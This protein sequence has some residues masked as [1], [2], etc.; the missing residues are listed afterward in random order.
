VSAT[1]SRNLI[2]GGR[3]TTGVLASGRAPPT[4]D[5][6]EGGRINGDIASTLEPR[7]PDRPSQIAGL[8]PQ[9]SRLDPR[10]SKPQASIPNASVGAS[11]SAGVSATVGAPVPVGAKPRDRRNAAVLRGVSVATG[12]LPGNRASVAW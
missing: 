9:V 5:F 3:L 10:T 12:S 11:A 2:P 1:V 4:V 6:D 8:Q 7:V